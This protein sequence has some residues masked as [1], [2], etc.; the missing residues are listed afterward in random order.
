MK[1][2]AAFEILPG[3]EK[4]PPS[5]E[6]LGITAPDTQISVTFHLR[7]KAKLPAEKL[8]SARAC[9][10][11]EK[12]ER[13]FGAEP[14][15]M[16]LV[17]DF[18]HDSGLTILSADLRKRILVAQGSAAQMMA[19]FKIRLLDGQSG[20]QTYRT[21][22]GPIYIPSEL[23]GVINGVFGLDNRPQASSHLR[24]K[25]TKTRTDMKP[26]G[27]YGT[28]LA[29]I[30]N[31]PASDGSAQTIG[32]IELGGG[33]SAADTMAYF[34][35][36]GLPLPE[37]T[38]VSLDGAATSPGKDPDADTEVALDLEVAGS[39]ASGAKFVVYFA[40]NTGQG[41]LQAILN[42][43]HDSVNNPTIISISWG[44]AESNFT[45]QE[46]N[47]MNEAFQTAS[48]LGISVFVAA[49]DDGADDNVGDGRCHVDFPASSPFVTSTGGTSLVVAG[50]L[51]K[52][53]VWNDGDYSATGGGISNFFARPAYQQT[54]SMPANLNGDLQG[55]GLPDVSAVAD[56]DT[57]YAVRSGGQ[58]MVVG[59]TSAVAPLFAGLC[60]RLNALTGRKIGL[61]NAA[62]YKPNVSSAFND[63]TTGNNSCDGVVGYSAAI[64]WDPVSG[65]GSPNGEEL[66]K[67]F[68]P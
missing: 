35:E 22:S 59:G 19:A 50:G 51:R 62:I 33:Y 24:F 3:S 16:K 39:V 29:A 4:N 11:R 64:G 6:L 25:K 67:L 53:S 60:A 45:Q 54:I 17:S 49:G 68:Q 14:E 12:V 23:I 20:E 66:L 31:F 37:I 30:Y 1:K 26:A 46:M 21:R 55:R 10:S 28:Q 8:A 36:L 52:E 13:D 38:T 18:A 2:L 57:G 65:F 15:E 34:E 9:L 7:R 47:A 27:F 61:L 42:A 40:A 41:F 56:P 63:I 58:W 48:S 32:I 43:V 44:T 5:Y